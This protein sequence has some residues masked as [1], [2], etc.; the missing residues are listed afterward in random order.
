[1]Y[2]SKSKF[3]KAYQCQKAIWLSKYHPELKSKTTDAQQAIFD[4]GH[5]VGN[6]A[7]QL[8]S[9]GAEMEFNPKDYEGMFSKTK[10]L[11]ASKEKYIYEATFLFEDLLI[12]VDI[13]EVKEDGLLIYE[14]KSSTSSKEVT[15]YDLSF[16]NYVLSQLGYKVLENNLITINNEYI[17][18]TEEINLKEFFRIENF[19]S[20]VESL[21]GEVLEIISETREI[22][23]NSQMPDI[24]IGKHCNKPYEC[25]FKEHCW[26]QIPETSVFDLTNARAKDFEL[27]SD[28]ILTFKDI[29]EN[30]LLHHM[31][32]KHR[33]QILSEL[34]NKKVEN[35]KEIK[36]FLKQITYPIY[37]L[38]FECYQDAIPR[39]D[40]LRPY[41]QT[42]FQFSL[43][44]LENETS[45][46]KHYEFLAEANKDPRREFTENL[47]EYI[48]STGTVLAYNMSFEKGIIKKMAELFSE[49]KFSLIDINERMVD[50]M[51]P[52]RNY[53]FYRKEMK[54]SYSIK[55]VLPAIAPELS[56]SDL[57][58]SDGLAAVRTFK[59]LENLD[60]LNNI[61]DTGEKISKLKS[62]LLEYCKQDT[63]SM[64]LIWQYLKELV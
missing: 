40:G 37:F 15:L 50:L 23:I 5:E 9:P 32:E 34:Y 43:H 47:I 54:G 24:D 44:T 13:L 53:W 59:D 39:W 57:D 2:I 19:D 36:R 41:E 6:L 11:I 1:M 20:E 63:Y 10:S 4:Q 3:L 33:T 18:E 35:K 14:V 55:Y 62:S 7:K 60:L 45:E 48:G 16:Q 46:L 22:L 38:D 12:M 56:Y 61:E 51:I 58:V 26:S 8:L 42:P 27:Y 17:K 25:D 28:G 64:V 52:F 29:Q 31:T 49:Y 30:Y 21:Q